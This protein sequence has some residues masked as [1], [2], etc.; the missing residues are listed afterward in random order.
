VY[1]NKDRKIFIWTWDENGERIR[2]EHD[3]KPYILLEDKKG[4]EKSIYGTALKK[5]EFQSSY[6]R[7]NFVKD[8]NIKRIYENLPPYQ[9]FLIDNY[10][11]VCE[12]D[13]FS[14]HPLKVAYLDL[15]CPSSDKFPEP[16]LAEAVINLITIYN[17]ES[18]MYH[19]FGLK[20]FHTIRDDVKYYWCKSEEEL[21]K[22]FIKL[23]QKEG[24]DV[25]SGWN[26]VKGDQKV[27]LDDRI[28]KISD[29][30]NKW[31]NQPLKTYGGVINNHMHTGLKKPY[32]I[33]DV[34]G[35]SMITSYD[36]RIMIHK[37][38]KNSYKNLNTLTKDLYEIPT[39]EI[40]KLMGDNDIYIRKH[41]GNN[42]NNDLTY[43]EYVTD[44]LDIL[45][46]SEWFDVSIVST[47]LRDKLKN[48]PEVRDIL[49]SDH[50][51]W[52]NDFWTRNVK[53]SYNNLKQ[54][55]SR[56]ELFEM[57]ASNSELIFTCGKRRYSLLLD[58]TI[59]S[60]IFKILGYIF[61]DGTYDKCSNCIQFSSKHKDLLDRYIGLINS[62]LDKELVETVNTSYKGV[63]YKKISHAGRL[64]LLLPFIYDKK[65]K[66]PNIE[67]ISRLSNDQFLSFVAG[68]MDGD[69][70]IS[71]NGINLCNYD[72]KK[73]NF[74]D[75][76]A[77]LLFWNG[78]PAR[79]YKNVLN[80]P[81]WDFNMTN[82]RKILS[83]MENIHRSSKIDDININPVK[84]T[85][86]KNK[87]FFYDNLKKDLI[88]KIRSI[89]EDGDDVE[90]YDI[91]TKEHV[92]LCNGN[93]VH[94]CAAF[95]VPYL[96]NRITFQLGKE[97][98]DKLSP[99]G[100]IYEKTNPNGKFGMPSKEYVIEG[101]SIL[102]YYVIY[103]K[104]NLEKQETYK[105]DN[106]G[107]VE[108]GIN[109]IQ[110]E[111]NLWELMKNDW[112]TYTS[113]NIRDV[114]ICVGLDQKKGYINLI[115]FLAYTGLCDLES[116]IR[117][118]PAMNGAI[119]IRARM[120]G[121]YIPT[122]IRPVTDF[123]APGGYVAEPKIGFAENIVSFDANSLYPS[124]MISLNLSPETKIGRVE[125][126][127]DKVKIHH[128]SGRLFEMTPENFKKFI[129]EEQ[130]A[131]TKAGFLF[132]QKKR[133]LVPEFLDN[134]YTKRKEMKNK[135]MECRKNG[136]KEGEQ[137]FDSIQYAYK[138]HLNSLYGYML[139][140]YA[141]LGDED[142][143]TSVTLTGQAVIKKSNDLFQDYVRENLPDLSES[144][145]QQSCV[146]GDTDSFF[147][148]L[149]M[150]GMDAKSDEFYELCEDIENYINE[151]I[152]EW[153]RKAL[154][155]TDPRF[156]F[157]RETICDAG[158]FIGK[159]YYVLHV[160][161]DEGTKVDKFKYR[162]VD[163]VKTTMPKK[164]KPY[165]KKVI[166]H[167]IMSQ[168]LK[169]T[170]DMFNEAYE[171]FK[172][173][174]IAEISKISGMNNFAEYSA[175]CNGMNTVKG[176]PSHL[177]AAY[178]HDHIMEQNGW[179]SKYDKFKSGDKV[180]MVYVKKP[181]KY[182]LDM[183]G[184][185]GDW[186]EEFDNIF[187]VDFEKMFSKVFYA[188][189]ERF[190]KA[191]GWKLRKPSENLTVELDDLFGC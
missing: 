150:F 191:V 20:N 128:V 185:K 38:N 95:D 118:L 149:K 29:L 146:Y 104:F 130:A 64:A 108:L 115:R 44:N 117:T 177:K 133:G 166:E 15:E 70:F 143:G 52:G 171:E 77:E 190:Y 56:D 142:I 68:M 12:D 37:K 187:K 135:M 158:I 88:V 31:R 123:R 126:D 154:R 131:L 90:M 39:G 74:L 73:F 162:G 121:E 2:E 170:N 93:L 125:K 105:L 159:K 67:F 3:F 112:H 141:P 111:G 91:E 155:S 19:V 129:N 27:W 106:I 127:G 34:F 83:K 7:N 119:A 144:L 69:G 180:R 65:Q 17:S 156:V 132:S 6:D 138:I 14:Q 35:G 43:R 85:I 4:T 96:V 113:Y 71:N 178:F 84:N 173:L 30:S 94:N 9:Q 101:L 167:M 148:S 174:S 81:S 139:N 50:Y 137:K 18:K 8:S 54:F 114:E 179:G 164:V 110:H 181:N 124:V 62:N 151:R 92:F 136:D 11:S 41:L 107:E 140:K 55:I 189:I 10:W 40:I 72:C 134:L 97:W 21:L 32:R 98:A 99:T 75:D 28:I 61:T 160:L 87:S 122:F 152:I 25:L 63:F 46:E 183:I 47:K 48:N 53:W 169:E 82:I 86:A 120:R 1:S 24:F 102:D 145:L 45:L 13:N 157:K 103:Q 26:C 176:M 153:A 79:I 58:D 22:S 80:I 76:L 168:S 5:R 184:F 100:R 49:P 161:D 57:I 163:V 165:V 60:D 175:R 16:E 109:K 186:P 188:A 59:D 66:H 51:W 78:I 33:E 89:E 182:N 116:A 36:H 23:F 42:T 147:V 172:N